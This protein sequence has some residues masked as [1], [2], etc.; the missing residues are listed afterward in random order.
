MFAVDAGPGWTGM[1]QLR[2]ARSERGAERS[3][4]ADD[5][6]PTAP[7]A[8]AGRYRRPSQRIQCRRRYPGAD[9]GDGL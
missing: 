5:G 2:I 8:S 7:A 1:P 3:A 9:A 4:C 6:R